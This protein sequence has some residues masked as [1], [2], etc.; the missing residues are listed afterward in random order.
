[1]RKLLGLL[2]LA[3]GLG[4]SAPASAH[5]DEIA[6]APPGIPWAACSAAYGCASPLYTRRLIALYTH[7]RIVHH[8]MLVRPHHPYALRRHVKR[9]VHRRQEP[10]RTH[11]GYT[12]GATFQYID[13]PQLAAAVAWSDIVNEG[14]WR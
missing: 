1:M 8:V 9:F 7:R 5:L 4:L 6:I 11:A 14:P 10:H 2:G 12:V 3:A 13:D